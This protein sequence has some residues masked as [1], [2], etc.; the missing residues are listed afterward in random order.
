MFY[1]LCGDIVAKVFSLKKIVIAI[2][3]DLCWHEQ[4]GAALKKANSKPNLSQEP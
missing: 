2:Y 1:K 3:E 4:V